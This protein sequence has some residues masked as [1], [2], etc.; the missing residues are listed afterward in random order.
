MKKHVT[1][2]PPSGLAVD[3]DWMEIVQKPFDEHN[4]R[5]A[6]A[7]ADAVIDDQ[8]E[9]LL[10]QL[11]SESK[12]QDLINELHLLRGSVNFDGLTIFAILKNKTVIDEVL[13]QRIVH[14]KKARNLVSHEVEGEYSLVETSDMPNLKS[15]DDYKNLALSKARNWIREGFSLFEILHNIAGK[16]HGQENYYFSGEFYRKN[17]RGK[18]IKGPKLKT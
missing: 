12:C 17:P 13:Y 8:A 5:E 2:T 10:R 6:F 4:F 7:A 1:F 9:S 15:D 11:Y 3:I 18:L 16:I 14:F